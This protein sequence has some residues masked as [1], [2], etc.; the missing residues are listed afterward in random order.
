MIAD[1]RGEPVRLWS[2]G[3][4]DYAGRFGAVAAALPAAVTAPCVLDGEVCALDERGRSSFS[5]LQSSEGTLV[6]Y[7]FD[8]L[9]LDGRDVTRLPL[10]ERLALL[11]EVVDP[12]PVVRVSHTYDDGEWLLA[13][14]ERHGLEGLMIKRA[15]SVYRPGGRSR[16]WLKLKLR[17]RDS[18]LI[19]GYTEGTGSRSSLGA[20]VLAER[21]DDGLEWRGDVGS[22]LSG[23]E[24]D[25]L[26]ALLEPVAVARTTVTRTRPGRVTWVEPVHSCV[27]E[28]TERTPAG[29]L[30]A[31]VYIR[32]DDAPAAAAPVVARFTPTNLDKVFF[33]ELELTK[34]DLIDYYL[35]VA[36]AIVEHLRG[37]PFTMKRFPDGIHGKHFFQKE[38]PSHMPE[39]IARSEQEGIAF[40]LVESA[41]AL[42]WMV[43]MGCIDLNAWSAR[44]DEPDLPD[45]V[46]FDLDPAEGTPF[47][48]VIEVA[49]LLRVALESLDL[50]S[51]PKTSGSRGIHVLVPIERRYDQETVRDFAH[52]VARALA[53][54]APE[55]VTTEWQRSRRH[56]VLIDAN[57]NGY[58][59]TTAAVYSVRP[60]AGATVSAP[61]DWDEVT[62]ELELAAF[63]MDVVIDR[64]RKRGDAYAPVLSSRRRLPQL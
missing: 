58:G 62:P 61:L 18:F 9:E 38:A 22:G 39:W 42:A 63:T 33:P 21:T 44:A 5:L 47:E 55:L 51:F 45:W 50:E 12:G 34:G 8:L 64:F 19:A 6:F 29:R 46:V 23:D 48:T 28:Y 27:V 37:R 1:V 2:R 56:G 36:P 49:L 25:R 35:A 14:A 59:R 11:A 13:E 31:P 3:G 16:D 20:L 52:A 53:H 41:D 26:M 7:A 30:R 54:T 15:T 60:V 43:N 17:Q 10:S 32:L 24:V 4:H 40:P 57:Q